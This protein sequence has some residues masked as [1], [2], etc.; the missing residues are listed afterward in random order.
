M[1][2]QILIQTDDDLTKL[3]YMKMVQNLENYLIPK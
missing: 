2:T 1:S 3:V